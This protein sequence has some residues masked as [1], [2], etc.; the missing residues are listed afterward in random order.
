MVVNEAGTKLLICI[1][2]EKEFAF[3]PKEAEFYQLKGFAEPRRCKP[4]RLDR[5]EKKE[6]EQ[7]L[8]RESHAMDGKATLADVVMKNLG[9]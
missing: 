5:K 9:S 4:C 7:R 3:P 2:C 8:S 6:R 1:S